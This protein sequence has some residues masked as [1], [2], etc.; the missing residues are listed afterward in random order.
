MGQH[1]STF[2]L[3]TTEETLSNIEKRSIENIV[4]FSPSK[5]YDEKQMLTFENDFIEHLRKNLFS[6][7]KSLSCEEKKNEF[8][9]KFIINPMIN[10]QQQR[11]KYNDERLARANR[12]S[13]TDE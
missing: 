11:T 13:Q 7:S 9:E 1:L 5:T 4:Y 6:L 12:L 3:D 8:T 10:I 2:T